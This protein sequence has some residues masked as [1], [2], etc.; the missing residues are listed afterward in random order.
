MKFNRIYSKD[1]PKD[2]S[3]PKLH[4]YKLYFLL[5][6]KT[7]AEYLELLWCYNGLEIKNDVFGPI[8]LHG[9]YR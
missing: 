3:Y 9:I 8:W 7:E 4:W 1:Y 5:Y 6:P 2:I